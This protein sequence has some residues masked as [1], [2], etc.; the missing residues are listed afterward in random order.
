MHHSISII[1]PVLPKSL[2]EYWWY[3]VD[4]VLRDMFL[5]SLSRFTTISHL[6]QMNNTKPR[7]Q[8]WFKEQT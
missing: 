4:M 5:K 6:L 1:Q 7:E 2:W 8:S 3:S